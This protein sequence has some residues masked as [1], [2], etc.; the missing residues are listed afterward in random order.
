LTLIPAAPGRVTIVPWPLVVETLNIEVPGRAVPIAKYQDG[1][2]L[3]A[4]PAKLV[5]LRWQLQSGR[6]NR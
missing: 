6:E 5:A 2:K 3:A 4:A 1:A